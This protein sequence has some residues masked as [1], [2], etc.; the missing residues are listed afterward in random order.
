MPGRKGEK[1][2]D[3]GG[4]LGGGGLQLSW[5]DIEADLMEEAEAKTVLQ[6]LLRWR[7]GSYV[8]I[9]QTMGNFTLGL[10]AEVS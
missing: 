2:M 7:S 9:A 3:D 8:L 6:L 10:P 4:G 1:R 5:P